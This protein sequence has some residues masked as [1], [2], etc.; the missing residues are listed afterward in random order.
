MEHK[1][2]GCEVGYPQ[3]IVTG[4][5][6]HVFKYMTSAT[7]FARETDGE[8]VGLLLTSLWGV[9]GATEKDAHFIGYGV[10]K[11]DELL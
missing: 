8:V 1:Y 7:K 11:G 6:N 10:I 3:Y 5:P 4:E 9:M 2:I